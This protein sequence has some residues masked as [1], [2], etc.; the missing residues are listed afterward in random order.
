M[1]PPFK[2]TSAKDPTNDMSLP[3]VH[4]ESKEA[5]ERSVTGIQEG[6]VKVNY[7]AG[8]AA[9]ETESTVQKAVDAVKSA[10]GLDKKK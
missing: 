10:V 5:E 2:N 1:G 3:D 9:G 8:D 6:A 7:A 4:A